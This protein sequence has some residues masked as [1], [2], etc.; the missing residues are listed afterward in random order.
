MFPACLIYDALVCVAICQHGKMR[1][2]S[3]FLTCDWDL[4]AFAGRHRVV[5]LLRSSSNSP[6]IS[7]AGR[8]VIG[9]SSFSKERRRMDTALLMVETLL[10]DIQQRF[11]PTA[12]SVEGS[13]VST[14][15]ELDSGTEILR[16]EMDVIIVCNCDAAVPQYA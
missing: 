13:Y 16:Y 12:E 3:K 8:F 15:Q 9:R 2:A 7:C 11:L 6:E 1:N 14:V 10:S 4:L 5:S